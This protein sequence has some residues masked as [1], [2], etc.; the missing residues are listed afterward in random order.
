MLSLN[1]LKYAGNESCTTAVGLTP[2]ASKVSRKPLSKTT[3]FSGILSSVISSNVVLL[4]SR[5]STVLPGIVSG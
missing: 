4:P 1:L 5:P 3:T 2:K